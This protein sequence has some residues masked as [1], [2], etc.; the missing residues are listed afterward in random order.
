MVEERP[1][2]VRLFPT[3]TSRKPASILQITTFALTRQET[4]MTTGNRT[5]IV[6]ALAVGI[7]GGVLFATVREPVRARGN[8]P[9]PSEKGIRSAQVTTSV[10]DVIITLAIERRLERNPA[11]PVDAINV[12]SDLGVVTLTGKVNNVLVRDEVG[13]IARSADGVRS[14]VNRL[15]VAPTTQSDELIRT[16]VMHSL[17]ADPAVVAAGIEPSVSNGVV[18]L[19]GTVPSWSQKQLASVNAGG[20][21]GVTS[22]RNELVVKSSPALDSELAH[23]ITDLLK[24]DRSVSAAHS[25]DD[26]DSQSGILGAGTSRDRA[27]SE[28]SVAGTREVDSDQL[29]LDSLEKGLGRDST[30]IASANAA[31]EQAVRDAITS[32]PRITPF[33]PT[34]SVSEGVVTLLGTVGNSAAKRAAANDAMNTLGVWRVV[35]LLKVRPENPV[36]DADLARD[37]QLAFARDPFLTRYEPRIVVRDGYVSLYGHVDSFDERRR[38]DDV[39]ARVKGVIAVRDFMTVSSPFQ[40]SIGPEGIERDND[41]RE[42]ILNQL[43]WNPYLNSDD[44]RVSVRDGVA[45]ITGTVGTFSESR[46]ATASA[47]E[48]GALRVINELRILNER[49]TLY[50]P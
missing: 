29:K 23:V 24:W 18:T 42:D 28:S 36:V 13:S 43:R 1:N 34:V 44:V 9:L 26:L 47:F 11:I 3:T 46:A 40:L 12:R 6:V 4:P 50:R 17:G 21:K 37:V 39:A 10:P 14:V 49:T 35:N 5:R 19:S 27:Y 45:T 22:V 31:V 20:V 7:A 48:G 30:T 15:V 32:D 41:V 2:H 16:G 33:K 38:A 8:D 25:R